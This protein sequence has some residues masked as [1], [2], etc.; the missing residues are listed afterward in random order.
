MKL[1]I[2]IKR[3][4]FAV[5]PR[6]L[7]IF[8]ILVVGDRLTLYRSIAIAEMEREEMM[9]NTPCKKFWIEGEWYSIINSYI[10]ILRGAL[11]SN[12]KLWDGDCDLD[13]GE[14]VTEGVAVTPL[15]TLVHNLSEN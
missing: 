15:P 4:T 9:M 10:I 5:G 1:E 2:K 7:I 11:L 3:Q 8:E 14:E 12:S 6:Q 13:W